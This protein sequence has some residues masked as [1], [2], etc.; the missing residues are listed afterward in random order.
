MK[1]GSDYVFTK[2]GF[3]INNDS[4][5]RKMKTHLRAAG[6]NDKIHFHSLRHSFESWLVPDE[7]SLYEV[8]KLLGQSEIIVTRVYSHL[9]PA[10]LHSTV[11]RIPFPCTE[12]VGG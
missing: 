7:V 6:L 10:K 12:G 9:Q 2:R 5:S 3:T 11:N 8:Q 1:K 4:V